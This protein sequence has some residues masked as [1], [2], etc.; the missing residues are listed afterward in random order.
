[1]NTK[2]FSL[3]SINKNISLNLSI[4]EQCILMYFNID[5]KWECESMRLC[6]TAYSTTLKVILCCIC[7]FFSLPGLKQWHWWK[8]CNDFGF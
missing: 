4:F 5:T 3:K 1:M 6:C 2:I 7:F 8:I